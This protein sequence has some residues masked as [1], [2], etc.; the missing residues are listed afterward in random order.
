MQILVLLLTITTTTLVLRSGDRI[1]VD[2]PPRTANGVVTFRVD[3]TLYSMP[4]A[5]LDRVDETKSESQPT[6][7][8]KVL[9]GEKQTPRL[10]L[11][12]EERKRLLA[13]LEQ[14]HSG[15]PGVPT[16]VARVTTAPTA[17]PDARPGD[18]WS[19]RERA[20]GYEES[21]RRAEEELQ[22]LESRVDDLQQRIYSFVALGYKASQF[23]YDTSQLVRAQEQ[24]PYARLEVTRAR[25][26]YEQFREDARRQGVLPGW[27]R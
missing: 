7:Q 18:E 26:A 20:R 4:A 9:D 17:Q 19:W 5:E 1:R 14:N 2:E 6:R 13:D 22:L 16:A 24:L 12:E 25:R 3:G 8:P 15:T 21:V 10:R 23:T 11:S 27:L